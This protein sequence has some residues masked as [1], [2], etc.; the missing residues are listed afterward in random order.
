[1]WAQADLF[2]EF[3]YERGMSGAHKL[4]MARS[5]RLLGLGGR[6]VS[7]V[8]GNSYMASTCNCRLWRRGFNKGTMVPARYYF[9][10]RAA[11]P[12]LTLK[13]DNSLPPRLSLTLFQLLSLFWSLGQVFGSE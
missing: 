2:Y 5:Q 6:G 7:Q 13:P 1:M 10:E 12:A 11:L 4:A 3:A 9:Q 8:N